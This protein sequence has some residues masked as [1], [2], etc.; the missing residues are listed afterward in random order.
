MCCLLQLPILLIY[1]YHY[2]IVWRSFASLVIPNK[3]SNIVRTTFV[4]NYDN[5]GL[6]AAI[7]NIGTVLKQVIQFYTREAGVESL[8]EISTRF[9]E[10]LSNSA[11][12]AKKKQRAITVTRKSLSASGVPPYKYGE[13]ASDDAVG[14]I[15]GLAWT[16]VGGD[17]LTIEALNLSR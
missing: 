14:K 7:D 9:V 6:R 11:D 3:R 4:K 1:H 15:Q 10:K 2:W 8:T 16:A 12:G 5:N 17:L 13:K